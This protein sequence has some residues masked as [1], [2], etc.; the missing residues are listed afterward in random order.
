MQVS[1]IAS[2]SFQAQ[3]PKRLND[4][5]FWE[6]NRRGHSTCEAFFS[7]T[8][9]I[10]TW[11]HD[12]SSLAIFEE[13]TRDGVTRALGF[14]SNYLA[15]LKKVLLPAKETVFDS[16]MALKECDIIDAENSLGI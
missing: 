7:Q 14:V 4:E 2:V 8:K 16:F 5:L 11:G 10:K 3:I 1:P 6:A 13:R 12:S 9:N 15:P